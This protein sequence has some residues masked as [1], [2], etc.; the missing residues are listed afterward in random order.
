MAQ[1][2]CNG[3]GSAFSVGARSCPEPGCKRRDAHED[4]G[5]PTVNVYDRSEYGPIEDDP[6][7]QRLGLV[8]GDNG[9]ADSTTDPDSVSSPGAGLIDVALPDAVEGDSTERV[10]GPLVEDPPVTSAKT[11]KQPDR[12]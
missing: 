7:A 1:W 10:A 9:A 2:I 12:P 4:G 8:P 11:R 3:C 5:D 6:V